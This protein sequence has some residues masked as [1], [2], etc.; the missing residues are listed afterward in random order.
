MDGSR[1]CK[2]KAVNA[3]EKGIYNRSGRYANLLTSAPA[4]A[5]TKHEA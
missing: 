5:G 1:E 2:G 3:E 4:A